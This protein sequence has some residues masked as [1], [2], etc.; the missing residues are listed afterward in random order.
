MRTIWC[1]VSCC[2]RD[3]SSQAICVAI[4]WDGTQKG[5]NLI[6]VGLICSGK[7]MVD[8]AMLMLS[9]FSLVI[10]GIPIIETMPSYTCQ[11]ST[12]ELLS[13]SDIFMMNRGTN[14]HKYCLDLAQHTFLANSWDTLTH[15]II[16]IVSE[17]TLKYMS[18]LKLLPKHN[19]A[20]HNRW[21]L[22]SCFSTHLF[23]SQPRYPVIHHVP[24]NP[25]CHSNILW[26]SWR[27]I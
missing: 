24:P 25:I 4:N 22:L 2:K 14:I 23:P 20:N 3:D 1:D 16:F 19:N 10:A 26:G 27:T 11:I 7:N 18:K 9:I 13:Q 5:T 21:D 15:I 17:I 8:E 12:M 6:S